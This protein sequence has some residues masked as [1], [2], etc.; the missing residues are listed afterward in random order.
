MLL[1]IHLKC[2]GGKALGKIDLGQDSISIGI[3]TKGSDRRICDYHFDKNAILFKKPAHLKETQLSISELQS[4]C[5][6]LSG[7]FDSVSSQ[8]PLE[9]DVVR[10]FEYLVEA[11]N[12]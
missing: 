8:K 5:R 11:D 7:V 9:G 6:V 10:E 12:C 3:Q 1:D 2:N 4:L